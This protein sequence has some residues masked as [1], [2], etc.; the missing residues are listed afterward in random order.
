MLR[1]VCS[2]LPRL[3]SWRLWAVGEPASAGGAP[4][5]LSCEVKLSAVASS[6]ATLKSKLEVGNQSKVGDEACGASLALCTQLGH[7]AAPRNA[8]LDKCKQEDLFYQ[9]AHA[10]RRHRCLR[11]W[12]Q[13]W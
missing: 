8:S 9:S 11:V 2:S 5:S 12:Q 3:P 6:S 7:S 13:E 10:R 4:N 1:K